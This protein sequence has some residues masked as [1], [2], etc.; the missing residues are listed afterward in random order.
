VTNPSPP[1]KP[2]RAGD[3]YWAK[4][5]A[6]K[7]RGFD[8][9]VQQYDRAVNG[10][11]K[12]IATAQY[13]GYLQFK[14]KGAPIAFVYPADGLPAG[15]E[16]WGVVN[17]APHPQAARLFMDW[18]LSVPGQTSYGT[19]LF[20]NS[21]RPDAPPPPGGVQAKELK[22]LFPADWN[23]FLATRPQF[24]RLWDKMTGLR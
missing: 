6:L 9:Y 15:P 1:R 22:L 2:I 19:S 23:A 5:T 8:S 16:T 11:D 24:V 13:S 4:F 20:V 7:P 21:A 3:D 18:L 17:N 10:Q 12:I 14:A